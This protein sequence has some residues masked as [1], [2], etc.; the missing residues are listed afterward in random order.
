[1]SKNK[2]VPGA[3]ITTEIKN[4]EIIALALVALFLLLLTGLL[5]SDFGKSWCQWPWTNYQPAVKSETLKPLSPQVYEQQ[6]KD[7]VQNLLISENLTNQEIIKSTKEQLLN[8]RV[9]A[10]YQ[11]IHLDLMIVLNKLANNIEGSEEEF[12][13]VLEKYS[14]LR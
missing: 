5:Q 7:L 3:P 12:F 10:A 1:M 2:K 11:A 4:K 14:W 13:T 9:P 6:V 8:V